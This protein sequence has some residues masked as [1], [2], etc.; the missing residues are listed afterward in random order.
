MST[1]RIICTTIALVSCLLFTAFIPDCFAQ[2]TLDIN[3]SLGEL[4]SDLAYCADNTFITRPMCVA[5]ANASFNFQVDLNLA[6]LSKCCCN[7]NI[8]ACCG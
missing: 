7:S 4:N 3:T 5:E 1:K 8:P 6:A 2:L